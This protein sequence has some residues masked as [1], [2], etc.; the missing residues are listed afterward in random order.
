MTTQ[1]PSAR[2]I[3]FMLP[4]SLERLSGGTIYDR[5]IIDGLRR[6]HWQV[7]LLVLSGAYP[8]PDA[9]ALDAAAN[10][11]ARL[12]DGT[13]VVADG[14]A[15][16]AM[17]GIVQSHRRRLHWIALVHHPLA[18]ETGLNA[19]QQQQ[20]F[21]NERLALAAARGVI[22][23]ST[24]TAAALAPYGVASAQI[25]VVE[26]GTRPAAL[27]TGSRGTGT[28][29]GAGQHHPAPLA[30]LC[31]ASLTP[32]KGHAVLLDALAGLQ[33][34]DWIL[35]C[36]GDMQRDAA[37]TRD[38][39]ERITALGLAQRVVLHGELD[40]AA[41]QD[42]YQHADVFV[43]PSYHEGYGMALAEALACGL[44]VVSTTGGAIADTVPANAGV[45]V[46]PGDSAALR[47]ALER[48]L[49]DPQWRDA[50]AA[51]A[52]RARACQHGWPVAVGRF[53]AALEILERDA[54]PAPAPAPAR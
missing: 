24:S 23:T 45:L 38:L 32:R 26:P 10:Q 25:R 11:V 34:R 53:A 47:M 17:P 30:L 48:V 35:H 19:A 2:R 37:T 28:D 33:G 46:P 12:S 44:P 7:D 4:G 1:G 5:Q 3:V 20:L 9:A 39:R 21:T 8:W 27:A 42:M 41:L 43:L 14:L 16:G 31:V 18:L 49:D 22:V 6:A 36:V 15:F 40:A 51:G 50:L 13:C 52:R 29:T 54:L